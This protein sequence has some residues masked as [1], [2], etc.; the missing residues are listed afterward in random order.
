M[1]IQYIYIY[2]FFFAYLLGRFSFTFTS[3]PG[4]RDHVAW[5]SRA[6]LLACCMRSNLWSMREKTSAIASGTASALVNRII[7]WITVCHLY[8]EICSHAYLSST[9]SPRCQR[10]F[11]H[12]FWTTWIEWKLLFGKA[13]IILHN[14][15]SFMSYNHH[16]FKNVLNFRTLDKQL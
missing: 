8:V 2:T 15:N 5:T 16:F 11:N 10:P 1:Y 6:I 14:M 13:C 12:I 9:N 3:N 7:A 4:F